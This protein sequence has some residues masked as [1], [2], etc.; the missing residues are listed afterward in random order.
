M[1][2]CD[3]PQEA[4][5]GPTITSALL[6][7]RQGT[8]Q[9]WVL[10]FATSTKN[11]VR[12][13]SQLQRDALIRCGEA[14]FRLVE[15]PLFDFITHTGDS[16]GVLVIAGDGST[17]RA[18]QLLSIVCDGVQAFG[19]IVADARPLEDWFLVQDGGYPT[20]IEPLMGITR[21][22]LW[23]R[24][25]RY[26]R[27]PAGAGSWGRRRTS[28]RGTGAHRKAALPAANRDCGVQGNGQAADRG[29]RRPGAQRSTNRSELREHAAPGRAIERRRR[30]KKIL[31]AWLLDALAKDRAEFAEALMPIID[32]FMDALLEK[33]AGELDKRVDLQSLPSSFGG[34]LVEQ[35][36]S[37]RSGSRP[38]L[39]RGLLRQG[40]QVLWGNEVRLAQEVNELL[41]REA[42]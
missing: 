40:I 28:I 2:D 29:N 12:V 16:P 35:I 38:T 1:F 39:I 31:P 3:Q 17:C 4:D 42:A 37:L 19:R 24:R 13:A 36:G 34:G 7:D 22:P 21:S 32:L 20:D 5:L 6:Y 25:N 33:L 41:L 10:E 23:M 9:H 18:G 11:D 14:E 26:L 15:A 30:I 8:H 27:E